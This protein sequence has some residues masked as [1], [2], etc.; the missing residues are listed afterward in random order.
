[1]IHRYNGEVLL[2]V[3]NYVSKSVEKYQP[4]LTRLSHYPIINLDTETREHCFSVQVGLENLGPLGYKF[5]NSQND[6]AMKQFTHLIR[7]SLSLER[8]EVRGKKPRLLMLLRKQTR[9]IINEDEVIN[10]AKDVGFEVVAADVETTI[11]FLRTAHVHCQ[12]M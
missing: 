4:Y 3:E 1:M 9:S 11:D 5:Q 7:E 12:L 8:S 2:V 10:L 6:Q